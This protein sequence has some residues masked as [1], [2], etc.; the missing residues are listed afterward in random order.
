MLKVQFDNT[1]PHTW[2][3]LQKRLKILDQS[4]VSPHKYVCQEIVQE[5]RELK[6]QAEALLQCHRTGYERAQAASDDGSSSNSDSDSDGNQNVAW[7]CRPLNSSAMLATPDESQSPKRQQL[8]LTDS[9]SE[10]DYNSCYASYTSPT[11]TST[12]FSTSIAT[13]TEIEAFLSSLSD[14]IH[15]S[16]LQNL[17]PDNMRGTFC[18][19]PSTCSLQGRFFACPEY[20]ILKKCP[21]ESSNCFTHFGHKHT[22]NGCTAH[23]KTECQRTHEDGRPCRIQVVYFHVRASCITLRGGKNCQMKPCQWGH[24]FEAIR[25]AVMNS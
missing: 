22:V 19:S 10:A 7:K 2:A 21:H 1:A 16:T 6:S 25:R 13:Q 8:P 11:S 9:A 5:G 3:A 4:L 18:H 20:A 24:D 15:A 23:H 14:T 12:T 17:C